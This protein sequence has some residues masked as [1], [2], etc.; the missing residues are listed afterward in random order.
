[1]LAVMLSV[2]IDYHILMVSRKHLKIA[3]LQQE[4]NYPLFKKI[5][6]L[7]EHLSWCI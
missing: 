4:G 5:E 3:T 1:M 6:L 2:E 7:L